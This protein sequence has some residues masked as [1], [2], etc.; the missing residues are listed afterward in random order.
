MV[1]KA[2]LA[3]WRAPFGKVR[4]CMTT[5]NLL[6]IMIMLNIIEKMQKVFKNFREKGG[7]SFGRDN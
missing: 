4:Y 6:M 5:E 1:K 3:V 7:K 2:R